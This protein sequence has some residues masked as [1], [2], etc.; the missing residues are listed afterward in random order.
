MDNINLQKNIC[1]K[2]KSSFIITNPNDLI[3][4][5][6]GVLSGELV[7]GVRYASPD[8]M[9]GWWITSKK[10]SGDISGL[11][12]E[13]VKHLYEKRPDLIKF[14]GLDYGFRFFQEGYKTVDEDIWFDKSIL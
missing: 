13:H 3:V 11:R 1:L 12:T 9:S 5:D 10:Y 14:L 4:I 2:Y 8:H 6:E 7:E